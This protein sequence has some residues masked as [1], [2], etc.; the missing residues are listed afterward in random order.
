MRYTTAAKVLL[1]RV[2]AIEDQDTGWPVSVGDCDVNEMIHLG[3][4]GRIDYVAPVTTIRGRACR[5]RGSRRYDGVGL[6]GRCRQAHDVVEIR[7]H[8]FRPALCQPP[9][10]C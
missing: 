8:G 1:N 4:L 2:L 3:G 5:V 9:S 10:G 7:S 6:P